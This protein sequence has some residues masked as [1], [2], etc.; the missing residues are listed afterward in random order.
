MSR[1]KFS[2]QRD[3]SP[4]HSSRDNRDISRARPSFGRDVPM[5][6]SGQIQPGRDIQPGHFNSPV[7]PDGIALR[8]PA[9]QRIFCHACA[10]RQ[11]RLGAKLRF[12]HGGRH[13]ICAD[14]FAR[15]SRTH[16]HP[17]EA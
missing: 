12:I 8:R 16:H 14:C 3:I 17:L 4:G 10:R 9:V 15:R 6:R 11:L 7:S 13:W 1:D 5:S 2:P